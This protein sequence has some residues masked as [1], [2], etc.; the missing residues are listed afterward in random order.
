[1]PR[2]E[3]HIANMRLVL[4]AIIIVATLFAIGMA[5]IR[6]QDTLPNPPPMNTLAMPP[7]PPDRAPD[8]YA[9]PPPPPPAKTLGVVP[10]P[11]KNPPVA[12][13]YAAL[14]K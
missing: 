8:F 7:A 2:H 14:H 1:M 10:K 3:K 11:P 5:G 6:T 13:V 9:D 12:A 4:P